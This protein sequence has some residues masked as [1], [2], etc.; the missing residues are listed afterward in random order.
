[1]R[2]RTRP[3]S[4]VSGLAALAA[5][6]VQVMRGFDGLPRIVAQ[7]AH[8]AQGA[9]IAIVW[10]SLTFAMA[11]LGAALLASARASRPVAKGAALLSMVIL[12]GA[13]AITAYMAASALGDPFA[14]YPVYFLAG[15]ALLSGLAALKA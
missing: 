11:V 7:L 2:E 15:A 13:G 5:A 1:M 4:I 12:G 9:M 3:L 10:H 8:P 14:F 6:G